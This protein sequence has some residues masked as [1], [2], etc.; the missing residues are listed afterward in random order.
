MFRHTDGAARIIHRDRLSKREV[1]LYY[2]FSMIPLFLPPP[3]QVFTLGVLIIINLNSDLQM[4][5]GGRERLHLDLQGPLH[6]VRLSQRH[7]PRL[8][9]LRPREQAPHR[10]LRSIG[11][12]QDSQS[13]L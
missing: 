1:D 6:R 8:D 13:H 11:P 2:G 3:W 9:R 12:G 5:G 4:L 7:L 10:R